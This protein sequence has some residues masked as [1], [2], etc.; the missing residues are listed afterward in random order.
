MSAKEKA[1]QLLEK[2]PDYKI[3]CII[4]YIEG[5]IAGATNIP[6]EDTIAAFVEGDAMLLDG[7]GQRYTNTDDLFADLED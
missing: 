4:A 5:I 7:S 2:V 1:I 3:D 6:N